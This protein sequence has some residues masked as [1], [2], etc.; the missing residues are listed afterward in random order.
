MEET[1][2]VSGDAVDETPEGLLVHCDLALDVVDGARVLEGT[3]T[4]RLPVDN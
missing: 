4:V 2:P 1:G 3:G